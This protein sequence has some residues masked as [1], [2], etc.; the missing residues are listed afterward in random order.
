MHSHNL[1]LNYGVFSQVR[2][3]LQ[4]NRFDMYFILNEIRSIVGLSEEWNQTCV[5]KVIFGDINF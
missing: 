5:V 2:Y 1:L 4:L 3:N